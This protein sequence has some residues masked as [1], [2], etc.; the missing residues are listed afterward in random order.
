MPGATRGFLGRPRRARDERLPPGQYDVG[1]DW[2]VLTAEVTP[3]LVAE[4]WS[5]TVD[6]LVE[7]PTT[8]TWDEM[9]AL[10]QSEDAAPPGPSSGRASRVSAWTSC[11]T[12]QAS[13][14]TPR[15]CSRRRPPATPPTCRSTT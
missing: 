5:M 11:S 14:R 4:R 10:P 12:R 9:H 1:A 13:G 6:G 8:W 7:T 2:P 3:H 15:S